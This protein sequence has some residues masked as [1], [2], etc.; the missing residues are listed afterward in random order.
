ME[1]FANN[2]SDTLAAAMSDTDDT[3]TVHS[4]APFPAIGDAER[5]WFCVLIDA[6]ILQVFAI[7]GT[8][9]LVERGRQGTTA[10]A[11][12]ENAVVTQILTAGSLLAAIQNTV[13]GTIWPG[14]NGEASPRAADLT[15]VNQDAVAESND[16]D[17]YGVSILAVRTAGHEVRA[18]VV[19]KSATTNSYMAGVV[20]G[21]ATPAGADS[22]FGLCL[23]E[24][25]TGKLIVF[26][27]DGNGGLGV[28]KYTDEHTLSAHYAMDLA[29]TIGRLTPLFLFISRTDTSRVY[30][31][32]VGHTNYTV[33]TTDHEDFLV[34]NQHG[35]AAD[36]NA[37]SFDASVTLHAFDSAAWG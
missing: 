8:D 17:Q 14:P 32:K 30:V 21:L 12:A 4:S 27:L 20:T 33:L 22:R 19:T 23:R 16:F 35:F 1:R 7:T 13:W 2:A 29:L 36:A 5:M 6:E 15:W 37:D 18:R 9:W 24:S 25:S 34:D 11:H 31:V 28:T 26:G 10:A 3:L